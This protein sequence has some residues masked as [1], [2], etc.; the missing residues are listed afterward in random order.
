MK[1]LYTEGDWE[2]K[3]TSNHRGLYAFSLYH[4]GEWCASHGKQERLKSY[5]PKEKNNE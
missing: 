1:V 2:I 5:I 3:D 4:K